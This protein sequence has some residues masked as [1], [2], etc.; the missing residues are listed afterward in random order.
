VVASGVRLTLDRE[1]ASPGETVEFTLHNGSGHDL[2]YGVD[3][4]LQRLD[5]GAWIEL[6]PFDP[7]PPGVVNAWPAIGFSLRHGG[8]GGGTVELPRHLRPG[9]HRLGK[10]VIPH[11]DGGPASVTVW[12]E[13]DVPEH[14]RALMPRPSRIA[15]IDRSAGGFVAQIS[16]FHEAGAPEGRTA[17]DAMATDEPSTLVEA[18]RPGLALDE[19]LEWARARATQV[20]LCYGGYGTARFS[21]GD[22]PYLYEDLPSWPPSQ[23]RLDEIDESVRKAEAAEPAAPEGF[24][25]GLRWAEDPEP[26]ED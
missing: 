2:T 16:E 24:I 20:V 14:G 15:W 11:S 17:D 9:H 26:G 10:P 18:S 1:I 23:R 22:E 19:A 25:L 21:A 6:T 5:D 13:F 8:V 12:A 4:V 3:F 7:L